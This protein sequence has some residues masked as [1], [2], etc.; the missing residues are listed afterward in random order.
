MIAVA[1]SAITVSMFACYG[2]G[3]FKNPGTHTRYSKCIN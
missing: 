3:L 1:V 2:G